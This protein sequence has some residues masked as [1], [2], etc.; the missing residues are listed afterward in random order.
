MKQLQREGVKAYEAFITYCEMDDGKRSIA[1]VA[2]QLRKSSQIIA[3]WSRT[4][5]WKTRLIGHLADKQR[6]K[7][8][9]SKAAELELARAK[10]NRR[11]KVQESAWEMAQALIAKAKEMLAFPVGKRTVTEKDEKGRD[12]TII[13]EPGPWRFGDAAR[14]VEVADS[15]ARMATGMPSKVTGLSDPEGKPFTMPSEARPVKVTVNV[16]RNAQTDAEVA[17]YGKEDDDGGT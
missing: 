11:E 15:L 7:E 3:R 6:I 14:I 4:H 16:M 10:A 8:E 17:L 9:A 13:V 2:K 1:R 12:K 5:G